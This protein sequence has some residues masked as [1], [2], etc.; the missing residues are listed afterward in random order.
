MS[1]LVSC[2]G[3]ETLNSGVLGVAVAACEKDL[4]TME[5]AIRIRAPTVNVVR[6]IST[7]N[8]TPFGEAEVSSLGTKEPR[9]K[10]LCSRTRDGH[11]GKVCEEGTHL[12]RSGEPLACVTCTSSYA[13]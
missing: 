2:R 9:A 13:R 7:K 5:R 11:K 8:T 6:D 10:R 12:G 4:R 1:A 3:L